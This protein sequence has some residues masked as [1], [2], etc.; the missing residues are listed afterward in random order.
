MTYF[1][2]DSG[3]S[4]GPAGGSPAPNV[5]WGH[6]SASA[7]A[8]ATPP[9]DAATVD[10]SIVPTFGSPAA[11]AAFTVVHPPLLW[12]ILALAAGLAGLAL[13][14]VW[15]DIGPL[16]AVAWVIG[17]PACFALASVFV[18]VDTSRRTQIGYS[19]GAPD[20]ATALYIAAVVSGVV[21]VM[22]AAVRLAF[23]AGR[24]F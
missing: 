22:V 7:P 24:G 3:R 5:P 23:W 18:S 2:S 1:G 13:A 20:L 11:P 4:G 16:A 6:L 10:R 21:A 9:N 17:G 19:R 8:T 15:G 14:A 12:V